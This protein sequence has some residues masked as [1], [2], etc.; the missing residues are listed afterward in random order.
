MIGLDLIPSEKL[1]VIWIINIRVLL[2][3]RSNKNEWF[4]HKNF[5]WKVV[6]KSSNWKKWKRPIRSKPRIDFLIDLLISSIILAKIFISVKMQVWYF[7]NLAKIIIKMSSLFNFTK[8][9][10]SRHFMVSWSKTL[11]LSPNTSFDTSFQK[12][13]FVNLLLFYFVCY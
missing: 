13:V 6:T 12:N 11:K 8:I 4:F 9:S 7:L 1:A 3:S 5:F 10:N 2:R